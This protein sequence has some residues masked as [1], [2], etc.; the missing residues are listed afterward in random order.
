L[1][2]FNSMKE[3]VMVLDI[4][5]DKV[6]DFDETDKKYLQQVIALIERAI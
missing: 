2:I 6:A 1:P 3:V 5:S 4:D